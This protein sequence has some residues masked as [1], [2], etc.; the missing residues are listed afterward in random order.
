MVNVD[1]ERRLHGVE[2]LHLVDATV[3][4]SIVNADTDTI[5]IMIGDK[6][7]DM[8]SLRQSALRANVSPP[9]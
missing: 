4:P 6:V 3:M 5:T 9:A 8:I 2:S 7:A 1:N